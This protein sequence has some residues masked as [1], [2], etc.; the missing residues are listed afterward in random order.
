V[1]PVKHLQF[2]KAAVVMAAV[3]CKPQPYIL[4]NTLDHTC[5]KHYVDR[6]VL[7]IHYN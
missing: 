2:I 1:K 4:L 5:N 7:H 3:A 6:T